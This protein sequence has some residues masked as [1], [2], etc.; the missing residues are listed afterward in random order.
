MAGRVMSNV[1]WAVGTWSSVSNALQAGLLTTRRVLRRIRHTP[2]LLR[3]LLDQPTEL[4]DRFRVVVHLEPQDHV[5]MQPHAAALLHDQQGRAL[6]AAGVA[7][8]RLPCFERR[9]E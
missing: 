7:P 6:F 4:G 3:R 9:D 8:G 5:V 1:S 2:R